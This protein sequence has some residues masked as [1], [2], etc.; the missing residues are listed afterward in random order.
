MLSDFM[1]GN[2]WWN[3]PERNRL[4]REARCLQLRRDEGGWWRRVH[5]HGHWYNVGWWWQ[6]AIRRRRH[7]LQKFRRR[8]WRSSPAR[9]PPPRLICLT[10]GSGY[11]SL[12]LSLHGTVHV[13]TGRRI[14]HLHYVHT[15]H[16]LMARL[17]RHA[18]WDRVR[19]PKRG[20]RRHGQPHLVAGS[21]SAIRRAR[22]T[23]AAGRLA[24][25]GHSPPAE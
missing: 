4:E 19:L 7:A 5:R 17:S 21:I 9:A 15:R 20:G 16:V 18:H 14:L 11:T 12:P 13:T 2:L 24:R 3:R 6:R 25:G 22:M 1:S 23:T 8:P 10:F